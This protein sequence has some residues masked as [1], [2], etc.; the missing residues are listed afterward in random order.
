VCSV[1]FSYRPFWYVK[2]LIHEVRVAQTEDEF[3]NR[4][5]QRMPQSCV[6][7]REYFFE[8]EQRD[9]QAADPEGRQKPGPGDGGFGPR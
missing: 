5:V 1:H 6:L 4:T 9:S 8:K 2:N 3:G 7:Q